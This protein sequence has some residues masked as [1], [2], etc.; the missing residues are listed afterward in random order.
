MVHGDDELGEDGLVG[1]GDLGEE[2]CGVKRLLVL[3]RGSFRDWCV[4][5]VCGGELLACR[6]S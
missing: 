3:E 4:C 1:L 2:G 5:G 6:L